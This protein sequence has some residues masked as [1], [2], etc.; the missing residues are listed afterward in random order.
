[1]RNSTDRGTGGGS[2]GYQ[3]RDRIPRQQR[4]S[5]HGPRKDQQD[6][7]NGSAYGMKKSG[8]AEP[9]QADITQDRPQRMPL[10]R[11]SAAGEASEGEYDDGG[12][13]IGEAERRRRGQHNRQTINESGEFIRGR[14]HTGT[15]KMREKILLEEQRQ[16]MKDI[17]AR[18]K[19][20][21]LLKEDR[22]VTIPST[23]TVGRLAMI[24]GLDLCECPHGDAREEVAD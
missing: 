6:A 21:M 5:E 2:E 22:T 17:K 18:E 15:D 14:Q 12:Q 4:D 1:M 11:G 19:R 16:R 13:G 9:A 8:R 3:G 10:S 24:F 20:E 7:A 23:T